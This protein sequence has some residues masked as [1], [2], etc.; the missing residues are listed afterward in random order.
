MA[1][2]VNVAQV[3]LAAATAALGGA[4]TWLW[5][6]LSGVEARL[7][8]RISEA[9]KAATADNRDIWTALDADRRAAA[10]ARERTL[11]RLGEMPTKS[12]LAALETRIASMLTH[13][14]PR[15]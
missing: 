4:F 11:E 13:H 2:E 3:A 10:A 12:D 1:Q 9:R 8:A 15:T 6:R 7:D 14:L 5:N